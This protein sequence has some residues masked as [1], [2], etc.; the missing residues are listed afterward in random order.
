MSS[1]DKQTLKIANFDELPNVSDG[2][3]QY[4]IFDAAR[5]PNAVHLLEAYGLKFCCLFSGKTASDLED[6]APYLLEL[7]NLSPQSEDFVWSLLENGHG[8]AMHTQLRLTELR[9]HLKKF[10]KDETDGIEVYVKFYTAMNFHYI[11]DIRSFLNPLFDK[12]GTVVLSD[13]DLNGSFSKIVG[14]AV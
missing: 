12:V 7:A 9:R 14:K 3:R 11:F 1:L 10:L 2:C 4:V 5:V 6:E 8:V 13:G